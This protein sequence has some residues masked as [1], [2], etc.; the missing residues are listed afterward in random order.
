MNDIV[1]SF[2]PGN[3]RKNF[4][5]VKE[6]CWVEVLV[7]ASVLGFRVCTVVLSCRPAFHMIKPVINFGVRKT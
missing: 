3:C 7:R 1:F 5:A 2:R 6:V 4:T